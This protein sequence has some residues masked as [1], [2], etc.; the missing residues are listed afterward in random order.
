MMN[1]K[2]FILTLALLSSFSVLAKDYV[3]STTNDS[4]DYF[5]TLASSA[6]VIKAHRQDAFDKAMTTGKQDL[7]KYCQDLGLTLDEK[8]IT[9]T[10]TR[11]ELDGPEGSYSAYFRTRLELKAECKCLDN[12]KNGDKGTASAFIKCNKVTMTKDKG[13]TKTAKLVNEG[14]SKVTTSDKK[15]GAEVSNGSRGSVKDI[16]HAIEG[17]TTSRSSGVSK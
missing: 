7:K 8:T 14:M 13:L 16:P 11:T 6:N 15:H 4:S 5:N 2:K 17:S 12:S 9:I 10:G 1:M 3:S